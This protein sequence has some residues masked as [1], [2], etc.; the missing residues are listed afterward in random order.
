MGA[1][2]KP[3]NAVGINRVLYIHFLHNENDGHSCAVQKMQVMLCAAER[4]PRAGTAR[5]LYRIARKSSHDTRCHTPGKRSSQSSVL[6][7]TYCAACL[8]R[9]DAQSDNSSLHTRNQSMGQRKCCVP[10]TPGDA[11]SRLCS[12][13]PAQAYLYGLVQKWTPDR[14]R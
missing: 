14:A 4:Q 12:F 13:C 6:L 2:Y 8:G 7:L 3:A 9:G 11:K 10:S 5:S 1:I